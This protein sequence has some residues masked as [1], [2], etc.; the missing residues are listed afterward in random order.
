MVTIEW[1][2]ACFAVRLLAEEGPVRLVDLTPGPTFDS[3]FDPV[4]YARAHQ[5]LVEIMGPLYGNDTSSNSTRHS[6]THLGNTLRYVRH[7]E[8]T[9]DG[10]ARL[11]VEQTDPESGLTTQSLFEVLPGVSAIRTSTTVSVVDGRDPQ[12]MWA[13]TS[14]ATGAGHLRR[15]Q[16]PGRLA[17]RVHLVGGEPLGRLSR[18]GRRG[19]WPPSLSAGANHAAAASTPSA[20]GTWSSG[21]VRARRRGP[22]PARRPDAGLAGRAQRGVAVGGRRAARPGT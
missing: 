22:E 15:R 21:D 16:R 4:T 14:F 20:T 13:V 2:T 18:C 9:V 1:S 7:E 5:P 17:R 3:P 19:W 8:S 11:M 6:G 10:V 12:V